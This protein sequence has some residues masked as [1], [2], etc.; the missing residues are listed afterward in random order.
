MGTKIW[1]RIKRAS[2]Y[3]FTSS[4]SQK[5]FEGPRTCY[6][7]CC[8]SA[9]INWEAISSCKDSNL[10][11]AIEYEWNKLKNWRPWERSLHLIRSIEA[12][13]NFKKR[14]Y[15]KTEKRIGNCG[16]KIQ[17]NFAVEHNARGRLSIVCLLVLAGL[18]LKYW[19]S[20]TVRVTI[21]KLKW[22]GFC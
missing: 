14:V 16:R 20:C 3:K 17:V 5:W 15:Y 10:W 1:I 9:I 19:E 11:I 2:N 12:V 8:H 13:W 6:K 7:K 22:V 18:S 4:K 21:V